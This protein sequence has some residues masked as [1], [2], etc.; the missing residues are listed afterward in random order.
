MLIGRELYNE[1]RRGAWRP[2][3]KGRMTTRFALGRKA[4]PTNP[5]NRRFPFC[6][7]VNVARN[8]VVMNFHRCKP[9]VLTRAAGVV[10]RPSSFG[11]NPIRPSSRGRSPHERFAQ[12]LFANNRARV[13]GVL[14][15]DPQ[16]FERLKHQQAP[17]YLWIG[18]SDSRVPANQIIGLPPGDVFVH[19]N[20]AN[21]VA[22]SDLNCL[23]VLHF[24]VEILKVKHV[25]LVGHYG[26]GGIAAAYDNLRLGVVDNWLQHVRDTVEAHRASLHAIEDRD[27]KLRR[28]CELHVAEQVVHVART[29]VV[30]GRVGTRTDA[31]HS[32]LCLR[33]RG[34]DCC[35]HWIL[36]SGPHDVDAVSARA[37]NAI[38][39]RAGEAI[40]PHPAV[41]TP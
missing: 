4:L 33:H 18:C 28:L 12:Q 35:A 19:R 13:D 41:P 1:I 30:Q 32:R 17:E 6:P 38:E 7:K 16:F 9:C 23:S 8:N 27:A 2:Q 39:S 10:L 22:H 24:A 37:L 21:V 40:A 14:R 11:R 36:I 26:C 29:T 31:D 5:P 34:T 20:V 25:L 3:D 15:D